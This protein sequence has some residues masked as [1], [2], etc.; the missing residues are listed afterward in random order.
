MDYLELGT[1]L[2]ILKKSEKIQL[3]GVINS[4]FNIN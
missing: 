2:K 3:S 1:L 4:L